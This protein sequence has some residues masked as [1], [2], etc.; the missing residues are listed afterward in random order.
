M[1][2]ETQSPSSHKADWLL[3]TADAAAYLGVS[4]SLLNK[5]RVL[6]GGPKYLRLGK[7][8]RYSQDDLREWVLSQKYENTSQYP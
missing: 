2:N 3:R 6:G 4:A 8:V 7:A 5:L 1:S